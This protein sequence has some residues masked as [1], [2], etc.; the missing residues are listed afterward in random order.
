MPL[1]QGAVLEDSH[2]ALGYYS[3]PIQ[4]FQFVASPTE[5]IFQRQIELNRYGITPGA[6]R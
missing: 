5:R 4:G 2:F 6:N 1:T 3:P